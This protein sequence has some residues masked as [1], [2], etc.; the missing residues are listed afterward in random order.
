MKH[1]LVLLFL[2][3]ALLGAGELLRIED[4]ADVMGT[5][6]TVIA[7]GNHQEQIERASDAAFAEARRLEDMLS[8]YRPSSEWSVVNRHAAERP[9]SVSPELFQLLEAC[10][11]YSKASEG[12]FDITVGPLMQVWG[13]FKGAGRLPLK[14]QVDAVLP[15]VGYQNIVLD[16][17]SRTVK[18]RRSGVELDPGGIGKGYAVDRMIGKLKDYKVDSALVTAG[19]SSI[20]AL[21][22]P[23]NDK[24]WNVQI[25]DPQEWSATVEEVYLK[26]ESMS[27]SGGYEK[28]FEA[29]GKIYSHIM[30]PRTG[31][32][33]SGTLSVSVIAPRTMD[34]E[35]WT[36]PFFILG[37]EWAAKNKPKGLRVYYCEDRSES[38]CAWLQ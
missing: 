9:V 10:V 38:P 17:A 25:R 7:Y 15:V 35:T 18:F 36:K 16:A 26:D 14:S 23:P 6:F 31:Y 5:T 11:R 1:S 4:N 37:R 2:L 8:N 28:F 21:G 12:T 29:E 24:G 33:A 3:P 34:S 19:G 20:Y 30:D 32:P 13:F 27:T 22:A